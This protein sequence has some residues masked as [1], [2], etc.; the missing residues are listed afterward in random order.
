M[1]F[2]S[3]DEV[4]KAYQSGKVSLHAQIEL[5]I[6]D[7]A[8]EDGDGEIVP[9]R[10]KT[11]VGRSLMLRFLPD[12]MPFSHINCLLDKKRIMR[13]VDTCYRR[14]GLKK[15]VV[16]ADR[17]MYAGF[18]Y[19][20]KSGV[21]F[22]A[23]D[24][25]VPAEKRGM[26][27]RAEDEVKSITGQF[28]SGYVTEGERYNKIVDIWSRTNDQVAKAM[29]EKISK[30]SIEVN[31]EL[32]EQDSLNPIFMMS[33]SGARGSEAQ[34]RQLAGMRGLM[35]KPDGSIIETP[36]TANF[37]EGLDV[38]QYFISTHG[39][40]KG[41]TD[42]ALKTAN[43]G[44]L[45]RRLVDVTQSVVIREED[46]K[47][48]EG[49]LLKPHIEGGE[50]VK[51]L[52]D[53]VLGRVLAEDVL[54]PGGKKTLIKGN[55]LLD[56][57]KVDLLVKNGIDELRVRSAIT[58]ETEHGI[59]ARCYGRDLARGCL[60]NI[61]EAVGIIAAQS[62][63]EPGT[64]LTMRTFHIGGAASHSAASSG[65]T[66]R[67]SGNVSLRKVRS[68][69]KRDGTLVVLSRSGELSVNDEHGNERERYK[70]P[71]GAILLVKDGDSVESTKLLAKWDPHSSPIIAE[72]AG[73]VAFSGFDEETA[74]YEDELTGLISYMISGAAEDIP[75][76]HGHDK[77]QEKG[78][79][80]VPP[81]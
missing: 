17:L 6:S 7:H 62:I 36:I 71:Y 37:R 56:E 32:I 18:Y 5:R 44:Y 9:R 13:L 79:E 77:R 40:R 57:D 16:F 68:V 43:S 53:R 65:I 19:A 52:R 67:Y 28:V 74:R 48:T 26:L 30:E 14:C 50:T 8:I 60:V 41:L 80:G 54:L 38:L 55:T 22:G 31:G 4:E 63:G 72:I 10:V 29:M 20:T 78:K 2:H 70:I 73:E 51:S 25:E 66:A 49:I 34:I 35:T 15:T 76:A 21:S 81:E 3:V 1:I 47:T 64:Q 69:K 75:V 23:D 42:T 58:C 61:G 46:C 59:C 45:T 24:M 33:R 11:T 39:A 12:K 27:A